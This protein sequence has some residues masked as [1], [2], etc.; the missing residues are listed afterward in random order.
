MISIRNLLE[1]RAEYPL[2]KDGDSWLEEILNET[3]KDVWMITVSST[4]HNLWDHYKR[5]LV[6]AKLGINSDEINE[7]TCR[8]VI[9]YLRDV[10]KTRGIEENSEY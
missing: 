9:N 7:E 8:M 5:N 3:R 1:K 10:T 6:H 2:S 4:L